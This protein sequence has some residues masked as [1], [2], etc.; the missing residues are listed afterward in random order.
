MQSLRAHERALVLLLTAGL[1]PAALFA[2]A[3]SIP[4]TASGHPD[5]S[6]TFDAA[7]LTP[8]E[9]PKEFG[10]K[11]YMTRKEAEKI[12]ADQAKF[13]ANANKATNPERDAP[14]AGGAPVVGFE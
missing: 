9:R 13:I 6:G 5:L 1:A 14:A 12:A 4:R 3:D 8:L 7:T 10:D 11:L 2:A